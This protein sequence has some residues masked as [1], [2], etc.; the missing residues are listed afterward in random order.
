MPLAGQ[1]FKYRETNPCKE[2]WI[3][4][5]SSII[6]VLLKISNRITSLGHKQSYEGSN[7]HKVNGRIFTDIK[8]YNH[9]DDDVT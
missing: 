1:P 3:V 9:D 6:Q 2:A 4:N 8:G 7:N 5:Q